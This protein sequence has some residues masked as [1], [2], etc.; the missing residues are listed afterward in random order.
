MPGLKNKLLVRIEATAESQ[1]STKLS[2][3]QGRKR[4]WRLTRV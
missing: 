3:K 4:R 1:V 2:L